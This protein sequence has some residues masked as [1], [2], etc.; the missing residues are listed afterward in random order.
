MGS[1]ILSALEKQDAETLAGLRA[2]QELDIQTAMLDV[3]NQQVTEAND[4]ITVLQN[5]QAVTQLRYNFY[6]S[7][8][9]MN[10][11]ETAAIGLQARRSD[12]HRRGHGAGHDR[13]RMALCDSQGFGG[14]RRLRRFA[15]GDGDVRRREHR[16]R[17]SPRRPACRGRSPAS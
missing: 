11:A 10:A 3:K 8:A 14:R 5:Q 7:Q 9:F 16:Q 4:Q 15:G 6:S 17:R 12:R 1:L 2:T 13:G